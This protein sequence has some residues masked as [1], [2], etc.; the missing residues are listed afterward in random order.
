ML[1][2]IPV[3]VYVILALARVS[4]GQ[5]SRSAPEHGHAHATCAPWDG[6]AV[7]IV[8][9]SETDTSRVLAQRPHVGL[10]LAAYSPLE[11]ALGR[12]LRVRAEAVNDGQSAAA[13]RCDA[14]G[15]CAAANT[16]TLWLA[17]PG[18]EEKSLVGWYDVMISG[19]GRLRGHFKVDWLQ[20]PLLCG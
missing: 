16:G 2:A 8:L 5:E 19:Y 11:R 10:E 12:R 20:T 1:R 3:L 9:S 18:S 6:S 13:W 15:H 14:S 17:R 4:L 7:R